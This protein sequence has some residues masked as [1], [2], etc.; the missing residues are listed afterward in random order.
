MKKI[1]FIVLTLLLLTGLCLGIGFAAMA[2]DTNEV[3]ELE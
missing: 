1:V 3:N 2:A